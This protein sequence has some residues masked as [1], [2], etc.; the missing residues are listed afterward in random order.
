MSGPEMMAGA[1]RASRT[2]EN[3]INRVNELNATAENIAHRQITIVERLVT[4]PHTE[5]SSL[6]ETPDVPR[7]VLP[8]LGELDRAV[9]LLESQL[10]KILDSTNMLEGV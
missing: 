9:T 3:I 7:E 6:R 5:K 4:G 10:H 1:T 2:I 8:E